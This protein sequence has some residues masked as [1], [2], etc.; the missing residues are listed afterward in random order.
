MHRTARAQKKEK[1]ALKVSAG[2]ATLQAGRGLLWR[3]F[4]GLDMGN[5]GRP[6]WIVVLGW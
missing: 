3:V 2:S 5:R 4:V 6:D 1:E